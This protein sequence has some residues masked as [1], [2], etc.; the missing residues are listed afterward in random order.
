MNTKDALKRNQLAKKYNIWA[1][2]QSFEIKKIFK[3]IK[4]Y[5]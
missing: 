1:I 4:A 3:S 2:N 5:F